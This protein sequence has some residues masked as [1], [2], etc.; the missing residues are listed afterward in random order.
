METSVKERLKKFIAHLNVGQ[1]KFCATCGL[2]AGYVNNMINSIQPKTL[3]KISSVYPELSI[4]WLLTGE[5]NMLNH[6]A[7]EEK[8]KTANIRYWVDVDATAG[9]VALYDDLQSDNFL[10]LSLPEFSDCTDAVNLYGD[11]MYPLYKSGQIIILK[12][13]V[14]DFI[15]YGNVYLIVTRNGNRMVKYVMKGSDDAHIRCVSE[16][17]AFE[18]FE[19]NRSSILAMYVVKGGITKSML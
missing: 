4:S 17:K 15:E 9:G 2:S 16:N 5:G 8:T 19:I 18:D 7:P 13:W 6:D 3:E 1:N 14:E 10:H 12:K 11:S